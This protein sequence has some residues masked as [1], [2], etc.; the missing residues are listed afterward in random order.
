[1][2]HALYVFTLLF[3]KLFKRLPGI[4]EGNSLWINFY[5]NNYGMGMECYIAMA[6]SEGGCSDLKGIVREFFNATWDAV[7]IIASFVSKGRV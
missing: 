6:R 5:T 7:I 2:Y 3:I 1:M 4:I